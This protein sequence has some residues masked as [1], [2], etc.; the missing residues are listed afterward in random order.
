[1]PTRVLDVGDPQ[2]SGYNADTVRLVGALETSRLE[3]VALSHCWGNL[4]AEEKEAFCTTTTNLSERRKGFQLSSL[5]NTFQDAVIVTRESGVRYLW[6]DSLCIIQYGDGGEDWK[7]ESGRMEEVFSGAHFTIAA[8]AATD[9]KSGFLKRD[10]DSEYVHVEDASS[11]QFYISNDLDS[12]D[13]DVD[14][15]QLNTRAWVMQEQILSRRTVHFTSRQTYWE[16]GEGIFCETLTRLRIPP[17][18]RYFMLD[19]NFPDRF[20][21]SGWKL[22]QSFVATLIK[23][24]SERKIT[25]QTDRCIAISGLMDRVANALQCQHRFGIFQTHI[26]NNLLWQAYDMDKE[27][28]EYDSYMPS[29]SWMA[30]S[31]RVSF[32]STPATCKWFEYLHFDEKGGCDHAI[33]SHLWTFRDCTLEP[34]SYP[35]KLV[36][37]NGVCMGQIVYDDNDRKEFLEERCVVIGRER[38]LKF[39][40]YYILVV[41]PTGVDGEYKRVGMGMVQDECVVGERADIRII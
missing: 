27:K 5:P 16:C 10:I 29:W 38:E 31:G 14:M 1:M 20:L 35:C 23:N 40:R 28:I 15:A 41:R 6:I 34:E 17:S 2:Q 4:S 25:F 30:Y 8:T 7:R 9:S 32:F 37:S 36:N 12:F 13:W 22:T 18:D 11:R 26:H 39:F 24:Y 19:P 3:Y 33:R 21:N